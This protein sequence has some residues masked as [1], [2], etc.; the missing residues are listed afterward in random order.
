MWRTSVRR[1]IHQCSSRH[2]TATLSSEFAI[3]F[4]TDFPGAAEILHLALEIAPGHVEAEG[5]A[6]DMVE[7]AIDGDVGATAELDAEQHLDRVV[8]VRREVGDRGVEREEP[9]PQ[10]RLHSRC[11]IPSA[12][13]FSPNLRRV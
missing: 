3:E 4:E 5:V 7:R 12:R 1:G 6:V 11:R 9:R 2:R 13:S 8:Q 10:R